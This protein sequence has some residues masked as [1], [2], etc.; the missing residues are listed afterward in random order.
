MRGVDL[1]GGEVRDNETNAKKIIEFFRS[2]VILY[3]KD[4]T[5]RRLVRLQF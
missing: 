3:I 2:Y 5:D 1:P 4:A